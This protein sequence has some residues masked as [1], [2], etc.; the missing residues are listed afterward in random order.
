ML[1]KKIDSLKLSKFY[2]L[3]DVFRAV[4]TSQMTVF[5]YAGDNFFSRI[6]ILPLSNTSTSWSDLRRDLIYYLADRL[7][8]QKS[9]CA[10]GS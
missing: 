3:G 8:E 10:T 9:L 1:V 2:Y 5:L 7:W 4:D 6:T